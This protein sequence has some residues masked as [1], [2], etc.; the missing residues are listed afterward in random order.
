MSIQQD[1]TDLQTLLGK[2]ES[3]RSKDTELESQLSDIARQVQAAFERIKSSGALPKSVFEKIDVQTEECALLREQLSECEA[4]LAAKEQ[5]LQAVLAKASDSSAGASV[6]QVKAL[7]PNAGEVLD[8][9]QIEKLKQGLDKLKDDKVALDQ[10]VARHKAQLT[11]CREQEVTLQTQLNTLK[12]Q[13]T[14]KGK[15]VKCPPEVIQRLQDLNRALGTLQN[16]WNKSYK[17]HQKAL[18]SDEY[19]QHR[20]KAWLASFSRQ[21]FPNDPSKWLYPSYFGKERTRPLLAPEESGKAWP[22]HRTGSQREQICC[23]LRE[24]M[25]LYCPAEAQAAPTITQIDEK[26]SEHARAGADPCKDKWV[27]LKYTPREQLPETASYV[28]DTDN[29]SRIPGVGEFPFPIGYKYMPHTAWNVLLELLAVMAKMIYIS[30]GNETGY[31]S[32]DPYVNYQNARMMQESGNDSIN[33]DDTVKTVLNYFSFRDNA[34][35]VLLV[36]GHD[37]PYRNYA[38]YVYSHQ[39]PDNFTTGSRCLKLEDKIKDE[40]YVATIVPRRGGGYFLGVKSYKDLERCLRGIGSADSGSDEKNVLY[41]L[42]VAFPKLSA[43]ASYREPVVNYCQR[44]LTE[45]LRD[46]LEGATKY[47]YQSTKAYLGPTSVRS[48]HA[49]LSSVPG[50]RILALEIRK[51]LVQGLRGR[52][53]RVI[54]RIPENGVETVA[55]RQP[56]QGL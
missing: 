14:G 52:Q 29:I 18:Q 8:A 47:L 3:L 4:K 2:L 53:P 15:T 51:A 43:L 7:I 48:S 13:L 45:W 38:D 33:I 36:Y 56:G 42:T 46:W 20:A 5:E 55:P 6:D 21:R 11:Q 40:D 50:P 32:V 19:W 54:A 31:E 34:R 23:V 28:F 37:S 41:K 35:L 1:I 17:A 49:G 12:D 25:K 16:A 39:N 24:L 22:L 44:S 26:A 10:Q 9:G 30:E 27:E